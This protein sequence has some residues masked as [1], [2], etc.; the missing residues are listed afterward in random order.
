M[1][2]DINGA[3]GWSTFLQV[4]QYVFDFFVRAA[5]MAGSMSKEMENIIKKIKKAANNNASKEWIKELKKRKKS[6]LKPS[7]LGVGKFDKIASILE[8]VVVVIPYL[9]YLKK[10]KDGVSLLAELVIDIVVELIDLLVGVLASLIC[11]VIPYVGFLLDWALGIVIDKF[12]DMIFHE[13]RMS[14]MKKTYAKM[15]KNSSDYIYWFKCIFK[16][17]KKVF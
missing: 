15:V 1:D 14:Q 17:F 10:I 4:M 9:S 8:I 16:T 11:K 2:F 12:L 3:L 7:S 13:N 5:Q 6:L